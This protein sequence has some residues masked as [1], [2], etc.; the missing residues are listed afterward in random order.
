[1]CLRRRGQHRPPG[2][3]VRETRCFFRLCHRCQGTCSLGW[4][5][6]SVHRLDTTYSRSTGP[7]QHAPS[8]PREYGVRPDPLSEMRVRIPLWSN[9]SP[10]R[11]AAA[12]AELR[13]Y[14]CA[15]TD[16]P[17]IRCAQ[18]I[19]HPF[20]RTSLPPNIYIRSSDDPCGD[21]QRFWPKAPLNATVWGQEP[22][23]RLCAL[24]KKPFG[25]TPAHSCYRRGC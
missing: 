23:G 1:M 4:D 22:Q 3:A 17:R 15:K 2:R 18:R 24:W 16:S 5:A 12:I 11:I 10:S 6:K 21:P 25:A 9:T 19:R 13:I 20:W 14:S 8:P 7:S